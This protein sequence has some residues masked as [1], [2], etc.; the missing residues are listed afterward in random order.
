MSKEYMREYAKQWR[1]LNPN[2]MKEYGRKYY[3]LYYR[4]PKPVTRNEKTSA[5]PAAR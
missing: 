3:D 5:L 1:A 4:K 2:Y